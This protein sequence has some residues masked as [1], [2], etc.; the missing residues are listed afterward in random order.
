MRIVFHAN[1]ELNRRNLSS[2]QKW[3]HAPHALGGEGAPVNGFFLT[4]SR[5]S[6]NAY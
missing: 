5:F 3:S 4:N 6:Q 1:L 2:L